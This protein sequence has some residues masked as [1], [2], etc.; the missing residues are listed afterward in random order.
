M[1]TATNLFLTWLPTILSGIFLIGMLIVEKWTEGRIKHEFDQ[2]LARMAAEL[3]K[4]EA[5]FKAELRSRET[6]ISSLRDSVLS[7]RANR[8]ALLDKR[9]FEAVEKIWTAVNDLA[10]LKGLSAAMAVVNFK[11]VAKDAE[12]PKIQQFLSLVGATAPAQDA[13][14]RNTARDEQPFVSELAWAYFSAYKA[15]LYGAYARY[16][17]L[18]T[19][20]KDADRY[21]TDEGVRE[22][23]RAALP[24]QRGYIDSND[25]GTYHYLLDEIEERLLTELRKSLA[26]EEAD[27]ADVERAK[28]I[29]AA[30]RSSEQEQQKQATVPS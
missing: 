29:T 7:G 18:R 28:Q 24:H 16:S 10:Q 15:I 23:L 12:D 3:R 4:S 25:P 2:K 11:A 19:G 9:R 27:K 26:G 14:P 21:I 30:V 20:L 5:Q 8:Q 17:I 6:E 1:S 22:I 13:L